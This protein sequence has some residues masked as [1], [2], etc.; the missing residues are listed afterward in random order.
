MSDLYDRIR[1]PDE[2]LD[3]ATLDRVWARISDHAPETSSNDPGPGDTVRE[4]TLGVDPSGRPQ[5]RHVRVWATIAASLIGIALIAIVLDQRQNNETAS[6]GNTPDA[7]LEPAVAP[8]ATNPAVAAPEPP[9]SSINPVAP[10]TDGTRFAVID[11]PPSGWSVDQL[12][13]TLSASMFGEQRWA[14]IDDNDAVAGVISFRWVRLVDDSAGATFDADTTIRGVPATEWTDGPENGAT[15]GRRGLSWV[16]ASYLVQVTSSGDART[17]VRDVIEAMVIDTANLTVTIPDSDELIADDDLGFTEPGAVTTSIALTPP[18]QVSRGVFV[19]TEPNTFG[20]D[21]DLLLGANGDWQ[22]FNVDQHDARVRRSPD[23]ALIGLAWLDNDMLVT[24]STN[25]A[26]PDEQTIEIARSIRFTDLDQFTEASDRYRQMSINTITQWEVH[27]R[28]VT[29]DGLELT[30]RTRPNSGGANAICL[31]Q[32]DTQCVT[33]VSEGGLVDGFEPNATVGFDLED[34]LVG[35]AWISNTHQHNWG[36]PLLRPSDSLN[37]TDELAD[38]TTATIS[39]DET[40]DVGRFIIIDV[41]AT[42]RPPGITFT[43]T[44]SSQPPDD[45]AP[46]LFLE[47][48]PS[49]DKPFGI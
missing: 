28:L 30:V 1:P 45:G 26:L 35:V 16:E 24:V 36:E 2:H 19:R 23:G 38:G 29:D 13:A 20:F 10:N 8:E 33:T 48:T 3:Q 6:T 4:W 12:R 14:L 18:N 37:P 21:L 34:R 25:L 41:P 32:P 5:R 42:E 40:T 15:V 49:I 17:S 27:D 7:S 43:Q 31:E 39:D 47:L 44:V 9:D 11:N 22:P 46:A